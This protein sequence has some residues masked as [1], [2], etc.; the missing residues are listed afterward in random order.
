MDKEIVSE[1]HRDNSTMPENGPE[2]DLGGNVVVD[3]THSN[4]GIGKVNRNG[5]N[6]KTNQHDA[7]ISDEI[8]DVETLVRKDSN[9]GD[10]GKDEDEDEDIGKFIGNIEENIDKIINMGNIA[11]IENIVQIENINVGGESNSTSAIIGDQQDFPTIEVIKTVQRNRKKRQFSTIEDEEMSRLEFQQWTSG[12]LADDLEDPNVE[13]N[14]DEVEY[15]FPQTTAAH[16]TDVVDE[17]STL[18]KKKERRTIT[19][20]KGKIY[21]REILNEKGDKQKHFKKIKKNRDIEKREDGELPAQIDADEFVDASILDE[22]ELESL[23]NIKDEDNVEGN[24]EEHLAVEAVSRVVSQAVAA[25]SGVSEVDR[26]DIDVDIDGAEQSNAQNVVEIAAAVVA[27]ENS[28]R[29]QLQETGSR[30]NLLEISATKKEGNEKNRDVDIGN[31]NVPS[32]T[33]HGIK[34]NKVLSKEL[35]QENNEVKSEAPNKNTKVTNNNMKHK[36]KITKKGMHKDLG[37]ITSP[38]MMSGQENNYNQLQ[39]QQQQQQQQQ[40]QPQQQRSQQQLQQEKQSQQ[41]QQKQPLLPQQENY[42]EEISGVEV[43]YDGSQSEYGREYIIRKKLLAEAIDKA[44][45]LINE[46]NKGRSF[47][48]EETLAIDIFIK[49]FEKINNISHDEFLQRIWGNMRK[50]DKFWEILHKVIPNR[51]RSSLYKHVRRTYHIF[52]K[53]GVWT[54]E[55]DL[56]LAELCKENEGKWKF[57][58]DSMK[59]MPED[60][61]DRWRNYVKCGSK[62]NVNQWT[63]QEELVLKDIVWKILEAEKEKL[64]K[65][66][67][68]FFRSKEQMEK[69]VDDRIRQTREAQVCPTIN[70]TTVSEMMGGTRSRIQC[71][72]KWKKIMKNESLEKLR[73][74][75]HD[76]KMWMLRSI[77]RLSHDDPNIEANLDWDALALSIPEI[78]MK[79]ED[80]EEGEEHKLKDGKDG[81]NDKDGKDVK[82]QKVSIDKSKQA[83]R[84][85]VWNGVDLSTC[86]QRLRGT[87]DAAGK[88]FVET[89]DLLL[90]ALSA[91]SYVAQ[92]ADM[93]V[94]EDVGGA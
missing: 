59:R 54:E 82:E 58:G 34:N 12:F 85:R 86:F 56:K 66:E 37:I 73:E 14:I 18:K 15:G 11:N 5:E 69:E 3:P 42:A 6:N 33:E 83:E 16:F 70:W 2:K 20:A 41:Q 7:N 75:N 93:S 51:T 92:L 10:P 91:E 13:V 78:G 64:R 80:E 72:Y 77:K 19:T 55:E 79:I 63:I 31:A 49:E 84:R 71:R 61:R 29:N 62:R 17:S 43:D 28:A 1:I 25:V 46:D 90:A 89:V 23:T 48:G 81:K 65:E 8:L 40:K 88:S 53:R 45:A 76:T 30:E 87:V 32:V 35:K 27:A 36:K 26:E 22:R 67:E 50:K 4:N 38:Q 24:D 47:N 39:Q 74:M 68:K 57:I 9:S 21:S 94:G 60:C 44:K 52:E